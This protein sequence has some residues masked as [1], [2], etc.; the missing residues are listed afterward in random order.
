MQ[1]C[2]LSDEGFA[3]TGLPDEQYGSA[4]AQPVQAIELFDL[5]FT[6][7]A[8]GREVKIL[9]RWTDGELRGFNA[10]GSLAFRAEVRFRLQQ[11]IEELRVAV[12][13]TSGYLAFKRSLGFR[14]QAEVRTLHSFCRTLGD[15]DVSGVRPALVLEFISGR[16][17]INRVLE[18][19]VSDSGKLLPIRNQ[20]WLC[21][22]LPVADDVT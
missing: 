21:N 22:E 20:S 3:H 19:E 10:S 6:D 7:R 17:P 13:I 1:A 12:L 5:R 14:F 2:G 18:A 8:I 4:F 15:V 11:R 16:G 9:E